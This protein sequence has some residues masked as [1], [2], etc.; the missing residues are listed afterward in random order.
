[1]SD[2]V[3]LDLEEVFLSDVFAAGDFAGPAAVLEGLGMKEA[4]MVTTAFGDAPV[5]VVM[6]GA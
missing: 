1:L 2:L 4:L 3:L 5:L 6:L